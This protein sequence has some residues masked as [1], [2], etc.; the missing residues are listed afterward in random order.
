MIAELEK[1][2]ISAIK[3]NPNRPPNMP[4]SEEDVPVI[5]HSVLGG[6]ISVLLED[7]AAGRDGR[8]KLTILSTGN[9]LVQYCQKNIANN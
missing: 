2:V 6:L 3:S 8:L 4:I 5:I 1:Q 9:A 7:V